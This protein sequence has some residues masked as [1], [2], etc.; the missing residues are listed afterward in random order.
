MKKLLTA[1]SFVGVAL[2]WASGAS[3]ATCFWRGGSAA[4]DTSNTASWASGSGGTASTCAATGGIPKQSGDIATFDGNSTGTI[5]V[6]SNFN[7]GATGQIVTGAMAGTLDFSANNNSLTFGVWNG[8]GSGTRTIHMGSGTFTVTGA[9]S[10]VWT[11]ATTTGLTWDAGTSVINITY[12][13]TTNTVVN[14]G[15][16][17]TYATVGFA[18]SSSGSLPVTGGANTYGTLNIAAGT[19]ITFPISVTQTISNAFTWTGTSSQP[20]G[21]GSSAAGTAATIAAAASS[22]AAWTAFHDMTFTGSPTA[23]NSFNL[24]GHN[25]GITITAPTGGAAAGGG[26]YFGG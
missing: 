2:C 13:G 17:L 23:S 26:I 18:L 15:T 4:W 25:S 8:T 21:V 24:G 3:A 12:S 14:M 6:N 22:T 1:L 7:L 16:G 5:T 11:M 19:F 10:T 20:I 9:G